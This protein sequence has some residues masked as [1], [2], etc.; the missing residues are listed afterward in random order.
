MTARSL[1]VSPGRHAGIVLTRR[2]A[3]SGRARL[4]ARALGSRP[5]RSL[6][7][8]PP[9]RSLRQG[10]PAPSLRRR[11]CSGRAGAPCSVRTVLS[12]GSSVRSRSVCPGPPARSAAAGSSRFRHW[13]GRRH[14][15]RG[16]VLPLT[17]R[18][19]G[20]RSVLATGTLKF[21][22]ADWDRDSDACG[23]PGRAGAPALLRACPRPGQRP[24]SRSLRRRESLTTLTRSPCPGPPVRSPALR[25]VAPRALSPVVGHGA[26]SQSGP[27][28]ALS[29]GPRP[30]QP[31]PAARVVHS[32]SLARGH[33]DHQTAHI[34]SKNSST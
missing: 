7:H 5:A 33:H 8:N 4:A 22:L 23:P 26:P 30:R 12:P 6:S 10:P 21:A 18:C 24:P 13:Q 14:A 20:A 34:V 11:S 15:R 25:L 27:A 19:A 1:R 28:C 16:S 9:A 32:R 31:A 17:C 2:C 3:R 29:Q